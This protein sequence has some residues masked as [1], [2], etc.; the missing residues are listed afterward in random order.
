MHRAKS[1]RWAW[2]LGTEEQKILRIPGILASLESR[3]NQDERLSQSPWRK[4]GLGSNPT[5]VMYLLCD[6]R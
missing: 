2:G 1:G 5:A 4:T 6:L 3:L